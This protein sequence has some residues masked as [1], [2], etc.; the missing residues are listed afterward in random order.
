MGEALDQRT[1]VIEIAD[2]PVHT[3]HDHGLPFAGE[4]QELHELG[5]G[6]S[7]KGVKTRAPSDVQGGLAWFTDEGVL[8]SLGAAKASYGRNARL[9]NPG[10]KLR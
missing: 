7:Q 8:T 6:M 4:P 10:F 3:V 5:F 1:Q 2:E 9:W